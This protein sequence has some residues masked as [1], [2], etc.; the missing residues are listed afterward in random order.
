MCLYSVKSAY[1]E[2]VCSHE[3]QDSASRNVATH[4]SVLDDEKWRRL[5]GIASII[6][7]NNKY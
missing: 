4:S 1:K 6:S 2:L 3:R 7:I 5:W